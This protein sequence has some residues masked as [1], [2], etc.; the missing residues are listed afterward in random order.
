MEKESFIEIVEQF[1]LPM[2]SGSKLNGVESSNKNHAIV[3]E[4]A[5]ALS[6]L[7]KP[8]IDTNYRIRITRH[9]AFTSIDKKIIKN[10]ISEI[11][12]IY[13]K[14][15]NDYIDNI[16]SLTIQ[17]A[18]AKFIN[19]NNYKS[20]L[21][22]LSIFDGWSLRT[23]EGRD[24]SLG[25]IIDLNDNS[26]YDPKLEIKSVFD[27]DFSALLSDGIDTAICISNTGF[28]VGHINLHSV[29]NVEHY[30]APL[31]FLSFSENTVG[32]KIGLIL[33]RNGDILIFKDNQLIFAKRR[34]IWHYYNHD[35]IIQQMAAGSKKTDE[36]VRK[37]IYA[38]ALDVSF[39]RTGGTIAYIRTTDV[40]RLNKNK[41]VDEK[42]ILSLEQSIKTKTLKKIIGQ[43]TF[44]KLSRFLRKELLGIDGATLIDYQGNIISVGAIIQIEAG[45]DG[46][47]RLA[48]TKTLAKYGVG[49]K[50]SS[51]GMIQGFRWKKGSNS[52]AEPIFTIG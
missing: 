19:S 17:K 47:G 26:I 31:R 6:I 12:D 41:T 18:I 23:Y 28:I 34:G 50:I 25:L 30:S 49:I 38:T 45:S 10:V 2:F 1:I 27:N 46:G 52:K 8:E 29:S 42:D 40:S 22:V 13:S 24:V 9:Q 5:G 4:E 36:S 43:K 48:S 44:P 51:D 20:I 7:I 35:L 14:I 16:I 15:D 39:S 37:S 32:E 33:T 3:A 21:N 11:A